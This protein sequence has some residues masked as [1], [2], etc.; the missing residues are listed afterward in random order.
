MNGWYDPNDPLD[1]DTDPFLGLDRVAPARR[2][3]APPPTRW[4]RFVAWLAAFFAVACAH[5]ASPP[6]DAGPPEPA[7]EPVG[8]QPYPVERLDATEPADSGTQPGQ[9]GG[10][11]WSGDEQ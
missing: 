11:L 8:A 4:S 6:P 3:I 9:G 7:P 2:F 1:E 10:G 5:A